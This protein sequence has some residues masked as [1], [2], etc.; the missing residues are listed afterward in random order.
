MHVLD[1]ARV[2]QLTHSQNS[3]YLQSD[4][5]VLYVVS[6]LEDSAVINHIPD[7]RGL[8]RRAVGNG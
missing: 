3:A 7:L 4:Y 8:D 5:D 2:V 6:A 1:L